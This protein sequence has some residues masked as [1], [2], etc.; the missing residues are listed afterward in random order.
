LQHAHHDEHGNSYTSSCKC[1]A[2]Q[3]YDSGDLN[4]PSPSDV[5]GDGTT[6][7]SAHYGSEEEQGI[8]CAQD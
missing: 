5:I 8:Y 3:G 7:E 6:N 1:A 2:Y 4:C